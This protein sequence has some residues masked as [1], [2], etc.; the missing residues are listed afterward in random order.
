VA[1]DG[2]FRFFFSPQKK[3]EWNFCIHFLC[4]SKCPDRK[5]DMPGGGAD[6]IEI[7]ICVYNFL[8]INCGMPF[9]DCC[10]YCCNLTYRWVYYQDYKQKLCALLALRKHTAPPNP[11]DY[12]GISNYF[13]SPENCEYSISLCL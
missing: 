11:R 2:G 3:D 8:K 1:R 9:Q 6:D 4:I 13:F 12:D 10:S 5:K 7:D